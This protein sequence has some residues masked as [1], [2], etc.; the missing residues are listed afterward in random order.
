MST[1]NEPGGSGKSDRGGVTVDDKSK[2][3]DFSRRE[4]PAATSDSAA[5]RQR[6]GVASDDKSKDF[7]PT[8]EDDA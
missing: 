2:H 1:E 6:G 4:E 8:D 7:K 3:P 5:A